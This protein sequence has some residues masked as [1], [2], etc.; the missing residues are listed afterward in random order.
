MGSIGTGVP[1]YPDLY[2]AGVSNPPGFEV[3]LFS[4]SEHLIGFFLGRAS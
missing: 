3:V 4:Y 2:H 1:I